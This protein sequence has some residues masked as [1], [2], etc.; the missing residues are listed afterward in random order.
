MSHLFS[1]Y[2]QDVAYAFSGLRICSRSQK[3]PLNEQHIFKKTI[4]I[5]LRQ[6]F[7]HVSMLGIIVMTPEGNG[8]SFKKGLPGIY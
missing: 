3:S 2:S 1:K 8:S 4:T 7:L 5:M 6:P